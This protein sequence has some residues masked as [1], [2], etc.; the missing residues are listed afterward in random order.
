D[1]S[2][3]DDGS[4]NPGGQTSYIV[5]YGF[6]FHV[7][8]SVDLLT[9]EIDAPG[10]H[11][12]FDSVSVDTI[13]TRANAGAPLLDGMNETIGYLTQPVPEPASLGMIA[14]GAVAMLG[15]RRHA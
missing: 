2:R 10:P 6:I 12:S 14:L 9:L 11:M 15:R 3:V 7:P 4:D 5:D 8:V 1:I 13:T